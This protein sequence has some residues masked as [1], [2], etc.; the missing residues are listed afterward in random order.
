MHYR[1][2]DRKVYPK[3]EMFENKFM[4]SKDIKKTPKNLID[5]LNTI[6]GAARYDIEDRY[7]LKMEM[8]YTVS[9]RIFQFHVGIHDS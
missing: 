3:T 8:M 9:N 7:Y 1:T 4:K 5:V 2:P 6:H